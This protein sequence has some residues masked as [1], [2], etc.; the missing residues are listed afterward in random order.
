MRFGSNVTRT[1]GAPVTLF[2]P[3]A[4]GPSL[5]QCAAVSMTVGDSSVPVHAKTPLSRYATYGWPLP[6]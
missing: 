5:K 3:H 4:E 1:R 2:E 6:S